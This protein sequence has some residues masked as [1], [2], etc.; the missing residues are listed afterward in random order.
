MMFSPADHNA[1]ALHETNIFYLYRPIG[2][3]SEKLLELGRLF[4]WRLKRA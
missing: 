2:F 1:K 4:V 3:L